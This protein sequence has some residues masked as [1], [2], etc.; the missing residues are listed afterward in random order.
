[1]VRPHRRSGFTLIE[2]LVV[3][4]IIAVLI[5]L[6]L[7]AVQKVREAAAT[8]SCKNNLHQIALAAHNYAAA[9]ESYFPPGSIMSKNSP[10][11][12]YTLDPP[13]AGPYTSVLMFLLPYI[14]QDNV[15]KQLDPKYFQY[16][17]SLVAWAYGTP[18]FDYSSGGFPPAAGPDGTGYPPTF[19]TRI[20]TYPS[21]SPN[22]F[23][24]P[25]PGPPWGCAAHL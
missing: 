22:P 21:P 1:M 16:D 11:L 12:G 5:G 3:I 20:N 15:Y 8:T 17:N 25:T 18:P 19:D 2:L 7:P 6:L 4:A 13:Y 24:Q 14:E 10:N 23:A 9:N